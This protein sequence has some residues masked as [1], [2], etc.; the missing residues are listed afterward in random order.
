MSPPVLQVR[1][2]VLHLTRAV[3]EAFLPGVGAVVLL[4][5]GSDLLVLPILQAAAGG[6]VV[7]LRTAAGDRAVDAAD[8]LR[9]QGV[10][11]HIQV[12]A[13]VAWVPERACLRATGLFREQR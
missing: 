10:E 6:Y 5:E 8:F 13:P 9:E 2:G 1:G 12:E 7:K 4:R 11:D 3:Y